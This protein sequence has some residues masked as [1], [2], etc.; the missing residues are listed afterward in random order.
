MAPA[1]GLPFAVREQSPYEAE[2]S[3][4]YDHMSTGGGRSSGNRRADELSEGSPVP[5]AIP[6]SARAGEI[7][8]RFRKE[9]PRSTPVEVEHHGFTRPGGGAEGHREAMGSERGPHPGP[10]RSEAVPR[11]GVPTGFPVGLGAV[12]ACAR[13]NAFAQKG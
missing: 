12:A 11:R 6:G 2:P 4:A 1:E 10:L 5:D 8:L 9:G 13:L 7:E 3:A